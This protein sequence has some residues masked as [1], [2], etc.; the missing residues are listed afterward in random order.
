MM[1]GTFY[2]IEVQPVLPADLERLPELAANMLYSWN[3]H[4]RSVF[5][6]LDRRL[7]Q[8]CGHNPKLLLRRVAQSRLDEAA[9]DHVFLE[10]YRRALSIYDSYQTDRITR[11]PHWLKP[12]DDHIAYFCAEFGLH[13]S[14][15]VYSGGLGILAGDHCK[16]ASDLGLPFTAVGLL[17]RHGYFTQTIDGHGNQIVNDTNSDF[18]DLP[19]MPVRTRDG[20]ELRVVVQIAGRAV[21]LRIWEARV[22]NIA[23]YLLDSDVPTNAESDRAITSRLYGGDRHTRIQQ[24]IVLGVGGVRALRALAITPTV[25][26]INEGHS[27]LQ[28]LERCG[29]YVRE[30]LDFDSALELTAAATVFTTHTPV[31]AGHDIFDHDLVIPY[32]ADTLHALAI[33]PEQFITLG[34]TPS[35]SG[36]FSMTAFALRGSRRHNGVSRIHGT[37]ASAMEGYIWPQIPHDENPLR[38]VTNGVHVPTFLAHEW[39]DLL[40]MRFGGAWRNELANGPYWTR[41]ESIPD[42]SYWSVRRTLKGKMLATVRQRLTQHYERCGATAGTINR[43]LRYLTD[44]QNSPLV[45]GFARRFTTYKRATLL[46]DD[47]PRLARILG[48]TER[49]TVLIF[50]GKA[51]PN[52]LPGQQLIRTIQE[53]SKQP[54]FEGRVILLENYDLALARTLVAGVDVWINTPQYPLEASGTSGQK[55][56]ING[57]LNLSILDGWWA[58]GYQANNGWAV[59][60]CPVSQLQSDRNRDEARAFLD[61]LEYEVLPLFFSQGA[62]GYPRDWIQMSKNAMRSV[63]PIFNAERMVR[64]Y[65]DDFYRPA[66]QQFH[67]LAAENR[68]PAQILAAWKT[69]VASAWSTVSLRVV[70]PFPANAQAGTHVTLK[71]LADL[72][73]LSASDV[74]VECVIYNND[75]ERGEPIIRERIAFIPESPGQAKTLFSLYFQPP[76]PGLQY[77]RVRMY[78]YHENL[79]HHLEMGLMLW[80]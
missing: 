79:A 34:T 50:A 51:H 49:P 41:I 14:L 73:A 33:T 57:V 59:A 29:E 6:R 67:T 36:G 22:G 15:P 69:R 13:E 25:W 16:A 42:Y 10:E 35:A 23:L 20:S 76:L 32:L 17:Y 7:W 45:L 31:A 28:I 30:G 56:A 66:M 43:A 37:V 4:V 54:E 53:F 27:A 3:H 11:H 68:R 47:L 1:A 74:V 62:L 44:E 70:D 71:V 19:I 26:H 52:D 46:F 24:E 75:D 72:G 9:A 39:S 21:L 58:E 61:A 77:Y 40:D 78:P 2:S 38:F 65:L 5:I 18:A 80:L 64:E 60:P 8:S 63:L 12:A 55:A 48:D